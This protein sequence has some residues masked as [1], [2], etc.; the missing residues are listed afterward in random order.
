MIEWARDFKKEMKKRR[1]EK[2]KSNVDEQKKYNK[3]NLWGWGLRI[4]YGIVS[5]SLKKMDGKNW[6]I[7]HTKH[8]TYVSRVL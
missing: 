3:L 1:D 4:L 6:Q 2:E 5:Q 7:I 8:I